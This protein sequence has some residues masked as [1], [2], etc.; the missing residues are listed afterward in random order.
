LEEALQISQAE[1]NHSLFVRASIVMA[2]FYA[3]TAT[4][5]S[6]RLERVLPHAPRYLTVW[7]SGEAGAA[8][9][10]HGR[11]DEAKR[12]SEAALDGWMALG[13]VYKL[14]NERISVAWILA[15]QGDYDQARI[16]AAQA[17]DLARR[18]ARTDQFIYATLQMGEF[19]WACGDQV[20]AARCLSQGLDMA[21]GQ[22]LYAV[23]T[24]E[25]QLG[26]G[27]VACEQGAHNHAE[28]LAAR[29]WTVWWERSRQILLD[30][31]WLLWRSLHYVA[32]M[33]R[34][35]SSWDED[36]WKAVSRTGR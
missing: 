16:L 12:W 15:R 1:G 25:A 31:R 13:N 9:Q 35:R 30:G 36:A 23:L 11:L 28:A 34:A 3:Q 33:L 21:R 22:S 6:A 10:Q 8:A 2:M 17:A 29:R 27:L 14:V 24:A 20:E 32:A 4:E 7:A 18:R 5:S 26:L 19:A